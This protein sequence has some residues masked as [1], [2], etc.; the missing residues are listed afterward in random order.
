MAFFSFT[1]FKNCFCTN[2]S[3]TVLKSLKVN[4]INARRFQITE[5][6]AFLSQNKNYNYLLPV[7]L[8]I[9]KNSFE[10]TVY[11][12]RYFAIIKEANRYRLRYFFLLTNN[13]LRR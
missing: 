12:K 3:G 8:L 10:S 9:F 1:F 13:Q 4:D 11:G 7:L 6:N 5:I 2:I